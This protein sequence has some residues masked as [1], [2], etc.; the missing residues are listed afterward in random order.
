MNSIITE[1][2]YPVQKL[3]VFKSILMSLLGVILFI[4]PYFFILY[5]ITEG[6]K[7][8]E[9]N[10]HLLAIISTIIII[11]SLIFRFIVAILNRVNFHY[12]IE[13]KF[14]TIKRGILSKQRRYIPY[15]VIQNLVVK[16]GLFDRILG[17]ASL[18]IEN[19]SQSG[20]VL[21][22]PQQQ[23]ILGSHVRSS[24]IIIPGLAKEHAEILKSIILQKMKENPI[25]DSQSG[26]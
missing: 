5:Q 25:E 21:V 19:A 9:A 14:L 2:N 15:G 20:G 1:K 4:V 10:F 13:E 8:D 11:G 22:V 18:I 7:E 17:L 3:W 16:Q 23:K 6:N 26:L 12:S 24:A